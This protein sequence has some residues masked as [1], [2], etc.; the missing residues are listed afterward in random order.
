MP[1]ADFWRSVAQALAA[2]V[3]LGRRHCDSDLAVG[4]GLVPVMGAHEG[5]PYKPHENCR[6][7]Q[8]P[9]LQGLACDLFS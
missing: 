2:C 3:F 8:R 5:H 4:A 7:P 9:A 6:G 1:Q